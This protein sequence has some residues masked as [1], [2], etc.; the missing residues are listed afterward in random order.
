M[1]SKIFIADCAINDSVFKNSQV[2]AI[3]LNNIDVYAKI[4]NYL[5][6]SI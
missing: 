4:K 1:T 3:I 2:A 5:K 6:I